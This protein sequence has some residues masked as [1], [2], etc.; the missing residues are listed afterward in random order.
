MELLLPGFTFWALS[1][2]D[3]EHFEARGSASCFGSSPSPGL[4]LGVWCRL[5]APSPI[6]VSHS[7]VVSSLS[8]SSM[9]LGEGQFGFLWFS[10]VNDIQP[11][12]LEH[13]SCTRTFL[14]TLEGVAASPTWTPHPE[15]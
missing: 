9:R 6:W 1:C 2:Q 10:Q 12:C 3:S 8:G 13:P 15:K 5:R 4:A 11:I 14:A 7:W